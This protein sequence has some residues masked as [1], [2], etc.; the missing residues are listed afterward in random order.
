MQTKTYNCFNY[1]EFDELVQEKLGFEYEGV[2]ANEWNNYSCYSFDNIKREEYWEDSFQK[3]ELHDIE[4]A[5]ERRHGNDVNI[6]SL[7]IYMVFHDILPEGNYLISV[8]W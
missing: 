7:L 3:Y 5:F 2:A 6:N 4:N 8:F 1:H